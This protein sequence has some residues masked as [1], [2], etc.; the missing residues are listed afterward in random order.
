MIDAQELAKEKMTMTSIAQLTGAFEGIASMHIARLKDQATEAE[1]FFNSVWPIY[2]RLRV[3][4]EFNTSR[5]QFSGEIKNKELLIAI[6]SEN[7]LSGDIDHRVVSEVIKDFNKEEH[8]IIVLGHHGS[9]QIAQRNVPVVASYRIPP[10]NQPINFESIVNMV[11]EYRTTTVYYQ[12]YVSLAIQEV[13]KIS[14]SNAIEELG[15]SVGTDDEFISDMS[16]IFEPSVE[17]VIDYM[18]LTMMYVALSQVTLFSRLAQ[19]ASRFKAM[20]SARSLA[21]EA[22]SDLT[23]QLNRVK[24]FIK[25]QRTREIINGLHREEV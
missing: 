25:D 6:T 21:Q 8:D 4:K 15:D 5:N 1:R 9:T 18:E 2:T 10:E 23:T 22:Q 13:K 14:L 19:H 16:Y 7:S 12:S 20:T 24:R 11:R 17:A 3:G